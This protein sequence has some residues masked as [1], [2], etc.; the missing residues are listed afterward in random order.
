[1]T[2]G[3]CG[4][5]L[6]L[7]L[8]PLTTGTPFQHGRFQGNAYSGTDARQRNKNWCAYVVHKNVSCAVVG[9]TDSFVQPELFPCPPELPDCAQQVIYRTHFRPTYKIAYKTVTELEWR[10]CPGYQGHDCMEVKDFRILQVENFPHAPS[11]GHIPVPQAPE[12]PADGQR[13]HPWVGEGHFGGQT[14]QRPLGGHGGSQRAQH[15]EEEVQQL[16][17]MVLDMQAR[18]TDMTSNLRLDFQED[19]SKML[20]TLLNNVREPAGARGT[21]THAFQLQDIFPNHEI[22]PMDEVMNKITQVTDDLASKTNTLDD[23]LGR[24]DR[25]DGQIRLLMEAGQNPSSS[26]PPTPPASDPDL[27]AYLDAKIHALREEL[28]EGMEI[29]LAD[30][31]NACDYKIM[32]V[33]EQCEGTEANYLSLAELIDS[34][35][36]DL[37]QEIQDLKTQLEYPEKEGTRVSDSV[38]AR[39]ENLEI[40]LNSS[41]KTVTEQCLSVEEKQ[42][43][44]RAEAIKDLRGTLEDKLASMED[45]LTTLLVDISTNSQSGIQPVSQDAQQ[46]DM[47]SLKSSVQTLEDRLNILDQLQS[48]EHKVNLAVAENLQQDFQSCKTATDAMEM[49]LNVKLNGLGAIEGQLVNYSSH[50]ENAH[51]E[52]S[53]MRSRMGILEDSLSDVVNQQSLTSQS[54]N[55]T[56][57][58]VKTGAEQELKDLSELHRTQHQELRERLDG[59]STEVKAEAEECRGKTEDVGKEIAHMDSRIVRMEDL[60]G[61]LDPI[62]AS[63]QRI[64][65]GLNKHVTAL[66]TCV[67]QLNGTVRAHTK[68]IGGV[69]GTCLNLQNHIANIARDLQVLTDNNSE[70]TGVQVAVDDAGLSQGS[71]KGLV[72]PVVPMDAS[73]P[74]PPVM[75]T[76]EAGPPGKMT[77]SK[78]PQGTSGSLMPVQG[79]AGAPA[80][81]VKST[82]SLMTSLPHISD[83][84]LPHGPSPQ[85]PATSSSEVSFSAGLTL[86]SFQGE[87]GIIRFNKVLV[88]DGGHYDPHTGVFTAPTDGRYLVSAVLAAQRGEKVEAVLSVSNRSIQRLDST[89]FLSGAAVPTSHQQCNCSSP[90]SLSLVLSLKRGDR[91][92]LVLTAGKLATSAFS[93]SE[94][95]SSFSAVLLYPSLSKR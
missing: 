5:T 17:Q 51:N 4:F 55:S 62:S 64:K 2:H 1:M 50:I 85:E 93:S 67:N 72:V 92:G 19:A 38:L 32:S 69:R 34:K 37:R 61:K 45:Q 13:N 87:V 94:I 63:L 42:R 20:I 77:S 71:S 81:P 11:T 78:L 40:H 12:Q 79:F 88:N 86:P 58:Q 25:H 48:N 31:K 44:E 22:T 80:S 76:G 21:E 35:E 66:W 57:G 16:S 10:C 89:G 33:Q 14:V 65:E 24:I 47:N 6:I 26:S 83:M 30:L 29:K 59:L 27:R 49:S 28:M 7:I 91:A 23:L 43:K 36:T 39:V 46:R 52:L 9:G 84:N 53:S 54:L 95:L 75:E 73:L 60:C 90:T 70:K 82:D 8:I 68:D 74:Q 3:L 18:M 15:L 41:Q 56:W